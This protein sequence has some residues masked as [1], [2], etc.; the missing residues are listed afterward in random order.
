MGR[1]ESTLEVMDFASG[2]RHAVYRTEGRIEAPNWS[3]DGSHFLFN[4]SG[5]LYRLP[6]GGG[7]PEKIDTGPLVGLNNDHGL[8][9]DGSTI[10]LSDKSNPDGQSRISLLRTEGGA[11]LLV[12][13]EGP[14]YW[15]GWSPDGKTL[16]YVAARGGSRILNIYTCPVDG[17][18]ERRLTETQCLDDGP[19]YSPDGRYIYFNSMRSGN[20]KLWR[21]RSDGDDPEQLTFEDETRD[22]FPHP[23]PDGR[24]IVFISFG[25]DVAVGDHPPNKQVTLRVV[26]TIGGAPRVIAR[27]IGGQGTLNVPSWSPDGRQFA[28]VSYK[29]L[30]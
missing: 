2:V 6:V 3:R 19:D 30:D 9:P 23:S 11:P 7:A 25:T 15:H 27:L 28:F 17:G 26:P 8:S 14:S 4:S 16:A 5:L 12:T 1:I 29:L 22:W 24:W 20:M 21:M 13:P 18:P 10:A